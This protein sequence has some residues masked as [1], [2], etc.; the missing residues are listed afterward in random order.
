MTSHPPGREWRDRRR[1][2]E[3]L[4]FHF[5][6]YTGSG[7]VRF[8]NPD[9]DRVYISAATPSDHRGWANAVAEMERM[10]GR[11]LPRQNS[12]HYRFKPAR[13]EAAAGNRRHEAAAR[14]IEAQRAAA[15]RRE[16]DIRRIKAADEHRREIEALMR[17][18]T[19]R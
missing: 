9:I 11:K 16:T 7:H 14:R 17:H 5:D 15:A 6:G 18:G 2:A 3:R 19:G 4:G 1:D 10:S 13:P 8:R 12:G